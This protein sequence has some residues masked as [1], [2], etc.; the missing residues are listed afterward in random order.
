MNG[1]RKKWR[2]RTHVDVALTK[3]DGSVI[4]WFSRAHQKHIPAAWNNMCGEP[5][6][7]ECVYNNKATQSSSVLRFDG[8]PNCHID[9]WTPHCAESA[10]WSLCVLLLYLWDHWCWCV[11]DD[12]FDVL[13][14]HAT[15]FK[16]KGTIKSC[17]E[18][19]ECESQ[20]LVS[21]KWILMI[22][23]KFHFT[24]FRQKG[25]PSTAASA[26]ASIATTAAVPSRSSRKRKISQGFVSFDLLFILVLRV[27]FNL[28]FHF[29][30][31]IINNINNN[32]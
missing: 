31:T 21:N 11:D 24:R 2:I 19:V 10:M 17:F 20:L 13:H 3:L 32:S 27:P 5:I 25:C 16:L 14:T 15:R 23:I 4:R 6:R 7:C 28:T 8:I 1:Y 12:G 9:F 30:L 26:N 18:C 22:N 29:L